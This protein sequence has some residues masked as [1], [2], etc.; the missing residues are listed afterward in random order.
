MQ[1]NIK[2]KSLKVSGVNYKILTK[3]MFFF[4]FLINNTSEE[5]T[6]KNTEHTFLIFS[7]KLYG[8]GSLK[9]SNSAAVMC[10]IS[11]ECIFLT[12]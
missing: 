2:G 12:T 3:L 4:C 10:K 9:I 8:S 11:S 6:C 7:I 1:S 5:A